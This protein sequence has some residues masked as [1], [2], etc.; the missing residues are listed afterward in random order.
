M[1]YESGVTTVAAETV[2]MPMAVIKGDELRPAQTSDGLC[3]A[4][5][6]LGEDLAEAVCAVRLLIAGSELL[7][8]EHLLTVC[9][10]EA[11]T[12]EGHALVGDTTLVDDPATF[13]ASL[14]V[15]LFI[16]LDADKFVL[17]GDKSLVANGHLAY[18][19]TEAFLV[20]LLATELK[21]LHSSPKDV[22]TAITSSSKVVVMAISTV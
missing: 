6:L 5:A 17:A 10:T 14:S 11:V 7:P 4:D 22:P 1:T 2:T 13:G 18:R 9:A 19:A 20:P 16:A 8:G 21:F 12:V 3:A 15:L